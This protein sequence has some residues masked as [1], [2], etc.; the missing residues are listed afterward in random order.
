[1][2]G[3]QV[4][5]LTER[6]AMAV[7]ERITSNISAVAEDAAQ[8]A[9][10][11]TLISLGVD[12]ENPREFQADMLHTRN[13]RRSTETVKS[14]GLRVTVGVIFTGMIALIYQHFQKPM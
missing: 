8:K 1:M 7:A 4:E 3:K 14:Q 5:A 10:K 11:Q 9:V 13:W 2:D 6:V 12:V